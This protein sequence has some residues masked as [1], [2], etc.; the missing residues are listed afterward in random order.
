MNNQFHLN[1]DLI[2]CLV[3]I[4]GVVSS[5][6]SYSINKNMLTSKKCE[7]GSHFEFDP[8]NGKIMFYH[9]N[10][11]YVIHKVL[12]LMIKFVLMTIWNFS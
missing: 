9:P 3:S 1:L 12:D 8:V 4:T 6:T 10:L 5:A 7:N 11:Y 2:V